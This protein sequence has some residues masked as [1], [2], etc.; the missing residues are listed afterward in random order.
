MISEKSFLK[1]NLLFC[2][3]VGKLR[4]AGQLRPFKCKPVAKDHVLYTN[5]MRPTKEIA[6]KLEEKLV[7]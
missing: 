1:Y 4:P 6:C 7:K 2:S 5:G 3:G